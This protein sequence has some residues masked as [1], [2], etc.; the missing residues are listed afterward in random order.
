MFSR[1]IQAYVESHIPYIYNT[2]GEHKRNTPC[3]PSKKAGKQVSIEETPLK[4]A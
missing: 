4:K 1:T 2:N 3:L